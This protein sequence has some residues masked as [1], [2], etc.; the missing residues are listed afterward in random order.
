MLILLLIITVLAFAGCTFDETQVS[1]TELRIMFQPAMY[2]QVSDGSGER[3][4]KD[5]TFGICAWELPEGTDWE[6][7]SSRAIPYYN[8]S[9]AVSSE[10]IV[11]DTTLRNTSKETLWIVKDRGGW[12]TNNRN[13][14]FI[15]YSPYGAEC[16]CDAIDGISYSI[17]MMTDQTDLLYSAPQAFR[18][19]TL[20]GWLVPLYFEH[21]LCK[22]QFRVKNHVDKDERITIK[23]ITIDDVMHRGSFCS[24]HSPQ[25]IT[26]GEA[27]PLPIFN[28][29]HVTDGLSEPIGREWLVIP[30]S[31]DTK[32]TVEYE[33]TT[34]ANT[35][36]IQKQKTLAL[37]T[38]LE[39]GR[40]YTYTLTVGIDDVKFL[41]EIFL[42]RVN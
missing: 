27:V 20:Q 12:V 25:W 32:I 40:C 42:H 1:D 36:I 31:L 7:G 34:H 29:S 16:D 24:L 30:Q 8:I 4:S 15:A 19:K 5:E 13:L 21:A 26:D 38:L 6:N 41:E 3:F 23:R 2:M 22:V 10:I 33:Y 37:K 14:A 18:Q 17:D 28:G 39:A 11:T 9:K 35:T